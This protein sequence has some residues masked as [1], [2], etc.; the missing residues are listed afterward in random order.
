MQ[1]D[2]QITDILNERQRAIIEKLP[3]FFKVTLT[4]AI[5]GFLISFA[6]RVSADPTMSGGFQTALTHVTS[7]ITV[8]RVV[9]FVLS[10]FSSV[11]I[12][13]FIIWSLSFATFLTYQAHKASRISSSII[14]TKPIRWM[15]LYAATF[16]PIAVFATAWDTVGSASPAN[17]T[18]SLSSVAEVLWLVCGT[19]TVVALIWLANHFIPSRLAAVRLSFLSLLL[20][21]SLFLTYGCQIT[22]ASHSMVFGILL[23]LMFESSAFSDLARRLSLHDVDIALASHIDKILERHQEIENLKGETA[24]KRE[25]HIAT[26]ERHALSLEISQ[27]ESDQNI[28]SQLADIHATKIQLSERLNRAQLT[29]IEK[30]IQT[31]TEVFEIV[32]NE[33]QARLRGG[34]TA[35]LASLRNEVKDMSPDELTD[36]LGQITK[37]IEANLT[38]IPESLKEVRKLLVQTTRDLARET[39]LIAEQRTEDANDSQ[40]NEDAR[41]TTTEPAPEQATYPDLEPPARGAAVAAK[42]IMRGRLQILHFGSP[43]PD[44]EPLIDPIT[45]YVVKV[46]QNCSHSEAF[47]V[48]VEAYNLTMRDWHTRTA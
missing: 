29:L 17:F 15:Q 23:Y 27:S 6:V 25:E 35:Q 22:I 34:I 24:L 39:K 41:A 12:W 40:A 48:E 3:S 26:E 32:N 28:R 42:D 20:Y 7:Q 14:R 37:T 33:T 10:L 18:L 2:D 45:R 21:T 38:G 1:R 46:I 16:F 47:C 43:W 19:A 5:L 30:R 36:R 13:L 4:L 44:G 8:P 31:L 9:A 11:V